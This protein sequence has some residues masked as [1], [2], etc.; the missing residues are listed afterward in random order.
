LLSENTPNISSLN[1]LVS[2][3]YRIKPSWY[4]NFR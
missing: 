4:F 3:S 1:I 2:S